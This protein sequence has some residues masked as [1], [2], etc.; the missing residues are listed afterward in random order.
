[1][2]W[3]SFI[4]LLCCFAACEVDPKVLEECRPDFTPY[5]SSTSEALHVMALGDAGTGTAG[6]QEVADAMG[7]YAKNNPVDFVL[8]LGDNFYED[9]VSS[10]SDPLWQ[11]HFEEVYNPTTL[12]MNFYAVLGNHDHHGNAQA[13][14][15]YT[16]LSPRWEMPGRYYTYARTLLDSTTIRFI[17][18]DT[19]SI[20]WGHA[21]KPAQLTWLEAVLDT[22]TADWKVVFGHHPIYSN[23]W[24]GNNQTMITEVEP[25]LT[26]HEVDVYLSGHDHDLQVLKPVN[27][28]HFVVSGSGARPRQTDCD[29]NTTYAAGELGFVMLHLSKQQLVCTVHLTDGTIDYST[30]LKT[31]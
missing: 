16:P 9:G 21:N 3:L 8:Y 22:C 13:Q 4:L 2:R 15:D 19:E 20:V 26:D 12:N 23:G 18:I 30:V 25:L 1:M 10:T 31:H 27:T 11:T 17:G 5:V 28:T 7:D 24:H 14:V 29:I 6:Q